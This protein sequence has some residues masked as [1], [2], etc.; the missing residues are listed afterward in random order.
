MLARSRE[1]FLGGKAVARTPLLCPSFSSKGFPDVAGI[2]ELMS[3][4]ITGG[5]LVSAYDVHHRKLS[6]RKIT[7]PELVFLDS[8]GYELRAEHDFSEPYGKKHKPKKWNEELHRDVLSRWPRRIPTIAV[9]YDTPERTSHIKSQIKNA[10]TLQEKFPD[11][12]VEILIKPEKLSDEYVPMETLIASVEHLR[13]FAAVGITEKELDASPLG[14]MEKIAKLRRAMDACN[15]PIPIHVFG[16]LDTSSTPL[17]F[18]SGAEI[19]DGLTWL[20]FGFHDG[21]TVYSQNYGILQDAN[22][23]IRQSREQVF[24]MWKNNYYYLERLKDQMINYVRTEDFDQF[25]NIGESIQSAY[26]QLQ[27]RLSDPR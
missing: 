1:L 26:V 12:P 9:S 8:G 21:L 23:L 17:Y 13:V 19:F 18:V 15:V 27:A 10:R 22:G 24:Q 14:R 20:R 7:F 5:V 2:V 16:S 4:F 25:K 3:E 6:A 11:L